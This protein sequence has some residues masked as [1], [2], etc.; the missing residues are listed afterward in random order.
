MTNPYYRSFVS[1]VLTLCRTLVF[2]SNDIAVSVNKELTLNG[3]AVTD[4]QNTW[5]Y[6]KNLSGEY[7]FT[8]TRMYITSLDTL[9]TIE[10]TKENLNIHRSTAKAFSYGSRYYKDLLEKFPTQRTL[11]HGIVNPIPMEDILAAEDGD[12]IYYDTSLVEY[13][14]MSLIVELEKHIKRMMSRW[15]VKGY[16]VT[17]EYYLHARLGVIFGTLPMF[18]LN[19][20]LKNVGTSE[21]HSFFIDQHLASNNR[22]NK[23]LP[24]MTLKQKLYL[25]RNIKYLVNNVGK[26]ETF[27]TLL[28]KMLGERN[29]PLARYDVYHNLDT[30]VDDLTP[31]VEI[32]KVELTDHPGDGSD[33][34]KDLDYVMGKQ[35]SLARNNSTVYYEERDSIYNKL[36]HSSTDRLKL[37]LYESALLDTTNSVVYTLEDILLSNW[38]YLCALGRLNTILTVSNTY[39]GDKYQLTAKESFILYLYVYFKAAGIEFQTVPNWVA[40][41]VY[42]ESQPTMQSLVDKYQGVISEDDVLEI[43]DGRPS[44]GEYISLSTFQDYIREVYHFKNNQV[45][46]VGNTEDAIER[47]EREI[48]FNESYGD[49]EVE[50]YDQEPMETWLSDRDIELDGMSVDDLTYM[51]ATILE[52]VS[53]GLIGNSELSIGNVQKAML[54]IMKSLS[55]YTVQYVQTINDSNYLIANILTL[56]GFGIHSTYKSKSNVRISDA[57]VIPKHKPKSLVDHTLKPNVEEEIKSSSD[58]TVITIDLGMDFDIVGGTTGIVNS[59][60][61]R[62]STTVTEVV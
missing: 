25:Y 29:L 32:R 16:M 37:K 20:R 40:R 27:E 53:S 4:D 52:Q 39:T 28:Q 56:R 49:Y 58:S 54:E 15:H 30:L 26:T 17:D 59:Q 23:Y 18:V 35:I 60:L 42:L 9:E 46:K 34:V 22:I 31:T 55:S 6:Y 50:L 21:V 57:T 43:M 38:G 3:V 11:I 44:I 41:G 5:K 8:D 48:L 10:F 45:D 1:K 51:A 36:K 13:Q 12:I 19:H 62:I 7:H 33:P 2:K 47:A 61:G 24:Q 14:E